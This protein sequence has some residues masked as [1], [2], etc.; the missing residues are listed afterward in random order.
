LK[1]EEAP[2]YVNVIVGGTDAAP[3][4]WHGVK[5]DDLS[6]HIISMEAQEQVVPTAVPDAHARRGKPTLDD[7]RRQ[8]VHSLG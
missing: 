8:Q 3:R 1:P 7:S 6:A 4:L 5:L 2:Q